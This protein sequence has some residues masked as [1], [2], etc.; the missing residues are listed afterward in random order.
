ML[1]KNT[2]FQYGIY[3][4]L[5]YTLPK[6]GSF[7]GILL[8]ALFFVNLP[9]E[10]GR[11]EQFQL[12]SL[13]EPSLYCPRTVPQLVK[14]TFCKHSNFLSSTMWQNLS[15]LTVFTYTPQESGMVLVPIPVVFLWNNLQNFISV[16]T[17]KNSLNHFLTENIF[18]SIMSLFCKLPNN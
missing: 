11:E 16:V 8:L 12:T 15:S 17:K 7:P 10:D 4:L 5:K 14:Y 18:Y 3:C 1:L 2:L 13:A 6:R 9:V